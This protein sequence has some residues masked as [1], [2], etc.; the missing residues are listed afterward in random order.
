[1]LYSFKLDIFHALTHSF[2][3]NRQNKA[4]NSSLGYWFLVKI[5]LVPSKSFLGRLYFLEHSWISALNCLVGV[6]G[7]HWLV[8]K[9]NTSE[10]SAWR[11]FRDLIQW[12]IVKT[13][14]LEFESEAL[15]FKNIN[16]S[17]HKFDFWLFLNWFCFLAFIY[18]ILKLFLLI[19]KTILL[20]TSHT[21]IGCR[22]QH[23]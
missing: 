1:M 19:R 20:S 18:F 21:S 13:Y 7:L 22:Q 14:S 15:D 10:N 6:T 23:I 2:W 17:W 8:G 4:Q 12:K 9:N 3:H 16:K 11:Y 5:P